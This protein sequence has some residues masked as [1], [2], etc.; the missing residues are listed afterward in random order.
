V[1][2]RVVGWLFALWWLSVPVSAGSFALDLP[3]TLWVL[4]TPVAALLVFAALW[5]APARVRPGAFDGGRVVRSLVWS[6]PLFTLGAALAFHA[7]AAVREGLAP[8]AVH[9]MLGAVAVLLVRAAAC[10]PPG[11]RAA[12]A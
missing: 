3:L 8:V 12:L 6:V 9:D 11:T 1:S 7:V 2:R 5:Q 4:I 10:S